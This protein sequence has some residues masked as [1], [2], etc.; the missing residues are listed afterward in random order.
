MATLA[1]PTGW[2]GT[3]RVWTSESRGRSLRLRARIDG[4]ELKGRVLYR[5]PQ[6]EG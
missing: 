2:L 4:K 6:E 3:I 1:E 5:S